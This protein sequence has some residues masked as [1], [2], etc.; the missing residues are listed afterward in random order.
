MRGK[1]PSGA[2][3]EQLFV[4]DPIKVGT[5]GGDV[6]DSPSLAAISWSW[7]GNVL[8]HKVKL[9]KDVLIEA[10]ATGRFPLVIRIAREFTLDDDED[11]AALVERILNGPDK[12]A[13]ISRLLH[14]LRKA[15]ESDEDS[16]VLASL[17]KYVLCLVKELP[18]SWGGEVEAAMAQLYYRQA[19][20]C[21]P[22]SRVVVTLPKPLEVPKDDDD[23]EEAA[24]V[25]SGTDTD[26]SSVT[27][28]SGGTPVA[29]PARKEKSHAMVKLFSNFADFTSLLNTPVPLSDD[30]LE[31]LKRVHKVNIEALKAKSPLEQ[32]MEFLAYT[33]IGKLLALSYYFEEDDGHMD[34]FAVVYDEVLVRGE[35]VKNFRVVRIDFDRSGYGITGRPE[36]L[37]DRGSVDAD[38]DV[39]ASCKITVDDIEDFPDV[40]DQKLY[41]WPTINRPWALAYWRRVSGVDKCK[42]YPDAVVLAMKRLKH[43][44]QVRHDANMAFT[45]LAITP[46]EDTIKD[47]SRHMMDPALL[48]TFCAH[49]TER[50]ANLTRMLLK[51]RSYQRWWHQLENKHMIALYN[52]LNGYN[53]ALK[54]RWRSHQTDLTV[55]EQGVWTIG[56]AIAK[57]NI[58]QG[59]LHLK[60]FI[61]GMSELRG[62]AVGDKLARDSIDE[63]VEHLSSIQLLYHEQYAA[64]FESR[65][66]R[67]S[68]DQVKKFAD[69]SNQALSEVLFALGMQVNKSGVVR[70]RR[71]VER[72]LLP[73]EVFDNFNKMQQFLRQ[74]VHNIRQ[75]S[76]F[77]KQMKR[78]ERFS[79]FS[80]IRL[81]PADME[82][83][84]STES[85]AAPQK[86]STEKLVKSLVRQTIRWLS[87]LKDVRVVTGIYYARM[88]EHKK[89]NSGLLARAS[90]PFLGHTGGKTRT[91]VASGY[92]MLSVCN[93]PDKLL[94]ALEKTLLVGSWDLDCFN[95]IFVLDLLAFQQRK[96]VHGSITEQLREDEVVA[97]LGCSKLPPIATKK[98]HAHMFLTALQEAIHGKLDLVD[99]GEADGFA[100]I[101]VKQV[102][103]AAGPGSA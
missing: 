25:A 27:A 50:R 73:E 40:R 28:S 55:A 61:R 20:D 10:V 81:D 21:I 65:A 78:A 66:G 36:F 59:L 19:P 67:V 24:S 102:D 17:L 22:K 70:P 48:D 7:H 33:G 15:D 52:E 42:V 47:L 2:K 98:E 29:A 58:K 46:Q 53:S 94:R 68:S 14:E 88:A 64:I 56:R 3:I 91:Q 45:R 83:K 103:A 41:Y 77:K 69:D 63:V 44:P 76:A 89:L 92:G 84:H 37:G 100:V 75:C 82:S 101:D 79:M 62:S 31:F 51:S 8:Q 9:P 60:R 72:L 97:E 71:G 32:V 18:R 43:H 23:E 12:A 39:H 4:D 49:F 38:R 6:P 35:T 16:V 87:E 13:F 86:T 80:S 95:T 99:G 93:T 57:Q 54:P 96:I 5:T 34:N 85:R 1:A 26:A 11:A 90:N 30:K 74:G